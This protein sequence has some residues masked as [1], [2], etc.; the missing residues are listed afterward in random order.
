MT[1]DGEAHGCVKV[2]TVSGK[3]RVLGVMIVGERAGDLIAEWMLAMRHD[4]GLNRILGT[5][6]ID[7]TL[8]EANKDAA[9]A[10]K[11]AHQPTALLRWVE[12]FHRWR[13]G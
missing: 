6:H 4:I 12:R 8:T 9:G 10:W 3:D 2:L 1:P 5:I 11:R 13:L 7:P